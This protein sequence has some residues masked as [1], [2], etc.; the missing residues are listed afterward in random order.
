MTRDCFFLRFFE[1]RILHMD[2]R[3]NF[4]DPESVSVTGG[5]MVVA[6]P[7]LNKTSTASHGQQIESCNSRLCSQLLGKNPDGTETDSITTW[8][9]L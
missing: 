8:Y 7:T 5:I 1:V 3:F 2:G 9:E 6:S 4:D